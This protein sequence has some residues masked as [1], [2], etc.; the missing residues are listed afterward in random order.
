MQLSLLAIN[1]YTQRGMPFALI[2]V[3]CYAYKS[4]VHV[5]S[6]FVGL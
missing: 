5:C 6:A 1:A 4:Q 3:M 2:R